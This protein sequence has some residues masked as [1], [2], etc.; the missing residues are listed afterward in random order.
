MRS[1]SVTWGVP[2]ISNSD[3]NEASSSG[4]ARK[5]RSRYMNNSRSIW[6]TSCSEN[7]FWLTMTQLL[8][9]YASSQS[10]LLASIKAEIKRRWPD[11]P[12]AT[13]YCVLSRFSNRRA[14]Y[15]TAMG[16]RVRYNAY[17]TKC[18]RRGAVPLDV[19]CT[20][21]V[22]AIESCEQEKSAMIIRSMASETWRWP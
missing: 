2:Y 1:S 18:D 7:R 20:S 9:L 10:I 8:L 19:F 11:D 5:S 14:K 4:D 22:A 17:A 15:T 13:G 12:R 16:R 21:I 6:L 3:A